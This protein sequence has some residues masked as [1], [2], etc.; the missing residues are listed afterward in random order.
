LG[1]YAAA[2]RFVTVNRNLSCQLTYVI[3][4]T[5]FSARAVDALMSE[6][7]WSRHGVR[8][9]GGGTSRIKRARFRFRICIGR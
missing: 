2:G 9:T 3:Q 5:G 6:K 7:S 1:R 4:V 8:S